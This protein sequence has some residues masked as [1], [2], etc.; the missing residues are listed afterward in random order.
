MKPWLADNKAH[1]IELLKQQSLPHA[2]II[3][4]A[5]GAGKSELARWLSNTLLCQTLHTEPLQNLEGVADIPCRQCKSCNLYQQQTHPDHLNIELTTSSIGVDQIRNVSRFFEK[6][7]QLATNQVVIIENAE[8]MTESAANALLKTL[9]EPTNNSFIILLVNDEQRLLPTIIS[10]CRHIQLK[11]PTGNELLSY[12]DNGHLKKL[13]QDPFINLTH[14][15]ELSDNQL[16]QQYLKFSQCFIR[17]LIDK[18]QRLSLLAQLND[19]E[20]SINW[21]ERVITNLMR[22]E[23]SWLSHVNLDGL[24]DDNLLEYLTS[25]KEKLW[26][27]YLLIK[28][29]N[30]QRLTLVQLNAEYNVE[31]L[32]VDIWIT[33]N[34]VEE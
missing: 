34:A 19:N 3:S 26:Q 14:L 11:P 2:L 9:E 27:V 5:H 7:A 25:N 32:L 1:F 33:M 22:A 6:T 18:N 21:L 10:R 30:K 24:S 20:N 29:F 23:A 8:S 28:Q 17:F 4:G 12:L 13:N 16:A 31:K 15:S